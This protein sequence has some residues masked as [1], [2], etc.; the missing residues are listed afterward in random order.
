MQKAVRLFG[1]TLLLLSLTAGLVSGAGPV[2][3]E[4]DCET[5]L[6]G[7][8]LK[9]GAP[10]GSS[11]WFTET[12][13]DLPGLPEDSM[14]LLV[15]S[16]DI[17]FDE[18][19]AGFTP[20]SSEDRLGTCIRSNTR[21]DKYNLAVQAGST[22]F[23]PITEIEPG[24]W[25]HLELM[26]K[27]S[28]PDSFMYL[29]LWRYNEEG[30]RTDLQVFANV[31]RRQLNAN[32]GQGASFI[33]LEPNT[34]VDNVRI[35]Q[36]TVDSLTLTANADLVVAGQEV[37]FLVEGSRHGIALALGNTVSYQL[38]DANGNPL[39]D[40]NFTIGSDGVLRVAD[41][42]PDQELIA[43]AVDLG[44][45]VSNP[46]TVSVKSNSALQIVSAGFN[47][48]LTK[49]VDVELIK[50]YDYDGTAVLVIEVF[51]PQGNLY[52]MVT[53]N[54]AVDLV[55]VKENYTMPVNYTVPEGFNP[56]D[57]QL[58]ARIVSSVSR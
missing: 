54:I 36:P 48:A 31:N 20:M 2:L 44:G 39:A 45:A 43:Q 12:A 35:F 40:P 21:R 32:V 37:E 58:K 52:E 16:M 15:W 46:V 56:A 10:D 3:V 14:E 30:E 8:A 13:V 18:E 53:R 4:Y 24:Q 49:L 57:W 7:A 6:K 1:L 41:F 23:S 25:Y 34:S 42:V 28:A 38:F 5:P 17:R 26:G 51:D 47:Q 33:R 9:P 55:P 27:Y 50:S 11:Y 29:L 22:V 19:G